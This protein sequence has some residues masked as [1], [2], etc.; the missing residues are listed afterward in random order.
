MYDTGLITHSI[1]DISFGSKF[2][3]LNSIIYDL[4]L[5]I[6]E[7]RASVRKLLVLMFILLFIVH[8]NESALYF[9]AFKSFNPFRNLIRGDFRQCRRKIA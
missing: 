7:K 4:Y 2:H 3:E 9:T 1:N 5:K 6:A 8:G